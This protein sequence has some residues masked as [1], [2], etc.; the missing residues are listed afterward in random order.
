MHAQ[1]FENGRLAALLVCRSRT[2][3]RTRRRSPSCDCLEERRL[4][5]SL[6]AIPNLNVPALQGYTQ[7]L[8]GSGTTDP[9]TFSATS[10]NPDIAVSIVSTTFWSVGILYTDP[11]DVSND[12]TGTL[13]FALFGNL[14]PQT[15]K[16]ITQFTNDNYYVN[17]GKFINKVAKGFAGTTSN[18]IQG[19]GDSASF[20]TD[21]SGQMG[22]PFANENLQQLALTGIDQL[23]MANQGGT[24]SNDAQFLINTGPLDQFFGYSHTVFGQL[25][26][27]SGVLAK[28]AGVPVGPNSIGELSQPLNPITITSTS[29]SSTSSNGVVLIDTTQAH[30]GE[31]ATI[32]VTANDSLNSTQAQRMFVVTTGAYAGS[33]TA[34]NL[35]TVNFKPYALPVT[36][37]TRAGTPVGTQFDAQA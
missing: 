20:N 23:V 11:H 5:A 12:F 25:V 21:P 26:S 32:T 8:D 13:T 7:P 35:E 37:T 6:A 10:S 29:L 36:A 4:L 30:P 14:T 34:S 28:I 27:G 1:L 33:T 22:T 2:T 16:M 24:D 15:V 19:G 9:Q 18:L 3:S 31:T 17:S